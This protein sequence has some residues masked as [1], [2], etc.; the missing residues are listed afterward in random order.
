VERAAIKE[1]A[2]LAVAVTAT[3]NPVRAHRELTYA[4]QV[5]NLGSGTAAATVL[6]QR[7]PAGAP[8]DN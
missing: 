2:D 7:L 6:T 8:G 4:A 1:T 5:T 3:P